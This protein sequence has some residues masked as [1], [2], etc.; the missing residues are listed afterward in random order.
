LANLFNKGIK[1]NP[2][3]RRKFLISLSKI[4]GGA[5]VGGYILDSAIFSAQSAFGSILANVYLA[6]NGTPAENVAKVIEMRFGGIENFIGIDDVVVINPNGQWTN[7]GGSNCACC[8]GLIDLIVNRP[9]GFNGEII[10]CENTQ[11]S[12]TGYWTAT[13]NQLLRNGPYN[14]NDMIAHY[15]SAGYPMVSGI[16][17]HR[18]QNDSSGWPIISGPAQGQ[19]WVRPEWQSPSSG[20]LFYLPYPIIRSPYTNRLIDLKNG[21]YDNGYEGMPPLKFIKMPNLNN[22]GDFGNQDY[23]GVT[24]A[25][26]S[27]LGI[28][29]L[30]NDTACYFNDNVHANMH[31]YGANRCSGSTPVK[32][33]LTGE[34]VGAWMNYCRKPDLVLTTAE[35]V[36]WGSRFG[37]DATQVRT[38]G[39]CEDP[40][41]I[42]YYMSKYVLW[43]THPQSV[44]FDPGHDI[45]NNTTRQTL[46]G[47]NSM[48]YGTVNEAEIGAFIYDFNSPT[49]FRFEID[50]M[51]KRFRTGEVSQQDVLE[52]IEMYNSGN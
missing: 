17:I 14:F 32:A 35:W 26:K 46:N 37:S 20:C 9:G 34:S 18:N 22:H 25:V 50:R 42:D 19:G 40:V 38:V 28:C 29:E 3:D 33:Y 23:A 2:I 41:T 6:K 30:E 5:L 10:F 11:F 43:P 48:G 45:P 15:H 1:V 36:G 4:T 39:L 52:L 21:V 13:G 44:Y 12:N 27:F 7:Q 47:C 51:I 24:S 49:T 16:R 31:A 8:M